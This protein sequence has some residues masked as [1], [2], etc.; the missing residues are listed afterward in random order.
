MAKLNITPSD[1]R[2]SQ[3]L[4]RFHPYNWYISFFP[5]ESRSYYS[6]SV[7]PVKCC[8]KKS[9]TFQVSNCEFFINIIHSYFSHSE[10]GCFIYIPMLIGMIGDDFLLKRYLEHF[11]SIIT[12]CETAKKL[13][14]WHFLAYHIL[15]KL[16][17]SFYFFKSHSDNKKKC[18]YSVEN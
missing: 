10:Y 15:Q 5:G 7:Y 13:L 2:D 11:L 9:V 4:S 18:L 16:L 17:C 12:Y 8:S 3:G 1:T 6:T 14:K